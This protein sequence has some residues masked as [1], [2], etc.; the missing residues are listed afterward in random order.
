MG[1]IVKQSLE[2][3]YMSLGEISGCVHET[4]NVTEIR[5]KC[6]GEGCCV[7]V[8]TGYV[9]WGLM[10]RGLQFNAKTSIHHG[11]SNWA[12]SSVC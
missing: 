12:V 9:I 5:S 8:S 3:I 4:R 11:H 6:L 2:T 10:P 7:M 1:T